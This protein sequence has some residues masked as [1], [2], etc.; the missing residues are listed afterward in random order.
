MSYAN[1]SY[2]GLQVVAGSPALGL[3]RVYSVVSLS[4]D[5]DGA[6]INA[7]DGTKASSV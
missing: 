1:I 3:G 4:R 5:N 2:K 6:T 7:F